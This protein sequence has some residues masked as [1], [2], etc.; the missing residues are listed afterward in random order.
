MIIQRRKFL[1][2]LASIL[3]APAIVRVENIMPVRALILPEPWTMGAEWQTWPFG[4]PR[5]DEYAQG[6]ICHQDDKPKPYS[7]WVK[8]LERHHL[9]SQEFHVRPLPDWRL[10]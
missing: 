9:P 3:A 10:A 2:G 6:S 7:H 8:A 5:P 4:A 1:I